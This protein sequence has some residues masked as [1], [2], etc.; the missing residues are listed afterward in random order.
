M[1]RQE[2]LLRMPRG[3]EQPAQ[4]PQRNQVQTLQFQEPLHNASQHTQTKIKVG[5]AV[6]WEFLLRNLSFK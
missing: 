1:Q 5:Q 4:V 3:M 2:T 6:T